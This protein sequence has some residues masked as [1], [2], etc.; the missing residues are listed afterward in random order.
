MDL[1]MGKWN[2]SSFLQLSE[3][4]DLRLLSFVEEI[5]IWLY[6]LF[7]WSFFKSNSLKTVDFVNNTGIF[8]SLLFQSP[9]KYKTNHND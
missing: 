7:N 3:N 4:K 1:N 2:Y 8:K 5:R 6:F 9:I